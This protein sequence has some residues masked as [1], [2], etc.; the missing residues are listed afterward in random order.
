[1]LIHALFFYRE[2]QLDVD[3]QFR[4]GECSE[5]KNGARAMFVKVVKKGP[6]GEFLNQIATKIRINSTKQYLKY[7]QICTEN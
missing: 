1:M 3:R 4:V 6:S 7:V 2:Y 5:V